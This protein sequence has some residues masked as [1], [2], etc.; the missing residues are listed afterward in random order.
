MF[1][2]PGEHDDRGAEIRRAEGETLEV[3]DEAAQGFVDPL[4][5]DSRT[6]LGRKPSEERAYRQ[7]YHPGRTGRDG[8]GRVLETSE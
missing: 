4:G 3:A 8:A 7:G 6:G 2:S 5:L 1:L